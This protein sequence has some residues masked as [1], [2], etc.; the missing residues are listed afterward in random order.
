[1]QG[2]SMVM[3]WHRSRRRLRSALVSAGLA[4]KSGQ[5]AYGR[6]NA[7]SIVMRIRSLRA[8]RALVFWQ[9]VRVFFSMESY[10]A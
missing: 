4:R 3:V 2:P 9:S 8:P 1:M 10:C 6:F 5:V 7:A